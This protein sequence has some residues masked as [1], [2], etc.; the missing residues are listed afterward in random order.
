MIWAF[1]ILTRCCSCLVRAWSMS[2]ADV[3]IGWL[4]ARSSL[5]ESRS[6]S[7]ELM[8]C[9]LCG[10]NF[11]CFLGGDRL[12]QCRVLLWCFRWPGFGYMLLLLR[13]AWWLVLASDFQEY[14]PSLCFLILA[15]DL[16]CQYFLCNFPRAFRIHGFSLCLGGFRRLLS[17]GLYVPFCLV[18]LCAR[19]IELVG[20]CH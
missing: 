5:G 13:G 1:Q 12:D 14:V 8:S 15:I 20:S 4:G 16:V 17:L 18:W 10:T 6:C 2:R 3:V 19:T 7:L 9:L 11:L